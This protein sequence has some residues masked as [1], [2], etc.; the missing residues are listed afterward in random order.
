MGLIQNRASY[1][2]LP[3]VFCYKL[4]KMLVAYVAYF[5]DSF[6]LELVISSFLHGKMPK[7][8]T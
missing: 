4:F 7:V 6:R 5:K 1:H 8:Y 3:Q 2:N